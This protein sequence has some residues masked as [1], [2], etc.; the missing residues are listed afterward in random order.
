M[1]FWEIVW[2]DKDG[3]THSLYSLTGYNTMGEAFNVWMAE[4]ETIES[5]LHFLGCK[6]IIDEQI[7]YKSSGQLYTD[8]NEL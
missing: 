4:R 6:L 2:K 7:V 1:W 5:R 8:G 3:N